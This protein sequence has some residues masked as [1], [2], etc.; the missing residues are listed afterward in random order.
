MSEDRREYL[1][2]LEELAKECGLDNEIQAADYVLLHYGAFQQD[3]VK[4][5]ESYLQGEQFY[6]F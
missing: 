4:F 3:F 6:G 1:T 5:C 2:K